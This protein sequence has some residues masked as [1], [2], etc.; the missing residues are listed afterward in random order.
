MSFIRC[1]HRFTHRLRHTLAALCLGVVA[2][3]FPVTVSAH[4]QL[5]E[6]VPAR[7]AVL[8][9]AP[10]QVVLTFD[11][12]LSTVGTNVVSVVGP[13]GT[14][15]DDGVPNISGANIEQDLFPLTA[16]G[17]YTVTYRVVSRDG[18][19]V[20]DSF[21]FQYQP[22]TSSETVDAS[23]PN[24]TNS[25]LGAGSGAGSGETNAAGQPTREG[26][27][28]TPAKVATIIVFAAIY[29]VVAR[30]LKAYRRKSLGR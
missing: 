10:E 26:L 9:A 8:A 28:L 24:S 27:R 13:D 11:D 25:T 5:V 3:A 15:V 19:I 22:P 7:D 2:T 12:A 17:T 21:S 6:S 20:N 23:T 18:H 16:V 1:P 4:A 29:F 14:A 30:W